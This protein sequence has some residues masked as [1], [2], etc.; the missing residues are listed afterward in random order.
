MKNSNDKTVGTMVRNIDSLVDTWS[1]PV[2]NEFVCFDGLCYNHAI[3]NKT[4]EW[5]ISAVFDIDKSMFDKKYIKTDKQVCDS[6]L[7]Y[8]I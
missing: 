3:T 4:N 7:T 1:Y 5:R 2:L 8:E 6:Y